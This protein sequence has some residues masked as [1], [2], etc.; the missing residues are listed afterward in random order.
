ME[1]INRSAPRELLPCVV[2]GLSRW[3]LGRSGARA[4]AGHGEGQGSSQIFV[5]LTQL[6]NARD[7]AGRVV[8]WPANLAFLIQKRTH[9]CQSVGLQCAIQLRDSSGSQL[10]PIGEAG[11]GCG[12]GEVIHLHCLCRSVAVATLNC[13]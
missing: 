8:A 3:N 12:L 4:G 7:S 5:R 1:L 6:L 13:A 9:R 11:F 2:A 10:L